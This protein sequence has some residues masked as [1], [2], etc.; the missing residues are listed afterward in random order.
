LSDAFLL[1]QDVA[2][3]SEKGVNFRKRHW[4]ILAQARMSSLE[5]DSLLQNWLF[6]AFMCHGTFQLSRFSLYHSSLA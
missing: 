2:R 6:G 5:R 4:S 1:K 3:S